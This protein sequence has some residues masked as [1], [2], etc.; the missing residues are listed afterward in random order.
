MRIFL[1]YLLVVV[2]A[3]WSVVT[4][5]QNIIVPR[6]CSIASRATS[7]VIGYNTPIT[8]DY[9]L[10]HAA[11]YLQEYLPLR[12]QSHSAYAFGGVDLRVNEAL[13]EEEYELDISPMGIVIEGGSAAGVHNGIESLLQLLPPQIYTKQATLP[14]RVEAFHIKDKPRFS[15]RGFML[16]VARTFMSVEEIKHFIENLAHHKINKLHLHLSDDEAWRI[17]ILSHPELAQTGGY[18]GGGSV[19]AARYGH[20]DQRYGGYYTQAEMREIVKFAAVRNIEIIPEIDLP[21]HSHALARVMPEVLCGY[22]P[23]T[24][25]SLGYDTRDALCVSKEENYALLEDIFRELADIFPSPYIHIGGDE[26]ISSQWRRCSDCGALMRRLGM[27]EERELQG[28][29]TSRLTSI[30]ARYG[31]QVAAWNEAS[32][33]D[34]LPKDALVY[35]WESV[36]ACRKAAAKGFQT[37]VMPGQWFYFDMKQSPSETGHDWAAIFDV[38]KPLSFDLAEQGFTAEELEN[39]AGFE[40]SFFSEIYLSQRE[41]EFDY[42]YYMTYPRICALSE[43]AWSGRGVWSSFSRRLREHHYPRL[44]A[45]GINFRLFPPTITYAEGVLSVQS[46]EPAE[47]CYNVVGDEQEYRYAGPIKT[48]T[49]ERYAFWARR[50]EAFSPEVGVNGRFRMLQPKVAITSSMAESERYPYSGAEGYGRISRTS[51]AADHGDWILYT[52]AEPVVCRRMEI[53]T[54]NKQLPRYIFN[55]GYVEVSYD[56]IKFERSAALVDGVGVIDAPKRAIKAVRIVNT[57]RGNGARFVTVQA[58]KIYP[59]L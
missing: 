18:R 53:A 32:E 21:G 19:V 40:A 5:A 29:F 26:V 20:S 27:A 48:S 41:Q 56:G 58:P 42:I 1:R 9:E 14:I 24:K 44:A 54:G 46:D 12:V 52:F 13:L 25:A 15:Y 16:D 39:V 38:R 33:S 22:S 55:A 3:V 31:K 49:P 30:L 57:E 59:I 36:E 2:L 35:G 17:E 37:V 47:I 7:F 34:S 8:H 50:G 6:P 10:R 11:K 28:Y 23:D 51:R 45:M 43:I 4:E